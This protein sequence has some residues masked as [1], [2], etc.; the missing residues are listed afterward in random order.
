MNQR[1]YVFSM[2]EI[3][4]QLYCLFPFLSFSDV[5]SFVSS[6]ANIFHTSRGDVAR[7]RGGKKREKRRKIKEIEPEVCCPLQYRRC[8][9]DVRA[10][11]VERGLSP[12]H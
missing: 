9:R 6:R 12:A 10:T 4:S 5:R 11:R 2:S 1:V 3:S 8:R 7:A